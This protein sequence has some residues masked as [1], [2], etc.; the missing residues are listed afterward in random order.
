MQSIQFTAP[1]EAMTLFPPSCVILDRICTFKNPAASLLT[2]L[3][4]HPFSSA[5]QPTIALGEKSSA[6]PTF[7]LTTWL[8]RSFVALF[9]PPELAASSESSEVASMDEDAPA[10]CHWRVRSQSGEVKRCTIVT[11]H[12]SSSFGETVGS[13]V[14][15]IIR[16][17]GGAAAEPWIEACWSTFRLLLKHS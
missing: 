14:A 8:K 6:C 7:S 11:E 5:S 4:C 9:L 13:C 17:Q 15:M 10:I 2:L 1:Q 16:I 12:R 3:I